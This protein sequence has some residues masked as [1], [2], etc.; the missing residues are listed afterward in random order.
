[1]GGWVRIMRY[2]N[3]MKQ[4]DDE[5]KYSATRRFSE[6]RMV[7]AEHKAADEWPSEGGLNESD[8]K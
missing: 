2:N 3:R 6:F 7:G 8:L 1:M 4:T 5:E